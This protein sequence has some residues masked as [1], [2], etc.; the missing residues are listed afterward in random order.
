MKFDFTPE[1]AQ[2]V[3][4]AVAKQL[5]RQK[6]KIENEV[7]PFEGA[8]YR[9]TLVAVKSG[10]T[11][12]VEAQGNLDFHKTLAG[13]AAWLAAGR[14]YV[15]FYLATTDHCMM[16]A[17]TLAEMKKHGVGWFVVQDD[18]NVIES[19]QARNPALVFTPHPTLAYGDCKHDVLAAVK[20]FNET[21]RKDGLRD[22]CEIA[23]RETADLARLA[24]RK[25]MLQMDEAVIDGMD[26]SSQINTLASPK[27]YNPGFAPI[28]EDVFKTD[29]I[30]S[31]TPEIFLT[32]K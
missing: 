26:W 24:S 16:N 25:K 29:Y 30:H 11:I 28:V 15:R 8:S 4:V 13:F 1:E 9:P 10:L 22:L 19:S 31:E 27:A 17:T 5:K 18:G 14:H 7:E 3:A 23:E 2:P 21:N 32:T 20:K 6:M 12:I